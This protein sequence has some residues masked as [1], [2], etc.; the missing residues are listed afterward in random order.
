MD[1]VTQDDQLTIIPRSRLFVLL[2]G[3][4]VV[5]WSE[6]RVQELETG[7]YRIYNRRD[8]G[9]P[10]T[11]YELGQLKIAG[12]VA[13]Y[14]K[15]FVHLHPLPERAELLDS[16]EQSRVRSYYLNTT[17]PGTLLQD[18]VRLLE[19]LSLA[20]NFQ[21]RVRDDF[22]VLWGSKGISFPKFDDVEKARH[23]LASAAPEAFEN[24]VVAFIETTRR[25]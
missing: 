3:A 20:E 14:D 17:L 13:S 7:H 19:N 21:A 15:E 9:A 2:D 16:W 23:L 10:I 4:F 6:N 25:D 11:D 8:F 18:V 1:Y 12:I 22:V 24:T 5:R